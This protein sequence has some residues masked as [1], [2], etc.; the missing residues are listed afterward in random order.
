MG[1]N[2]IMII[3]YLTT[4]EKNT[5]IFKSK[6]MVGVSTKDIKE[7]EK[8]IGWE[9]PIAYKE[10]LHLAGE[11]CYGLD[12]FPGRFS[13]FDL[14]N[15]DSIDELNNKLKKYGVLQERPIW[16]FTE[17]DG[18]EQFYFFYLD[19]NVEDPR[20]WRAELTD[21]TEIGDGEKSLSAFYN[22]LIDYSLDYRKRWGPAL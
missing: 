11:S 20:V 12:L 10:F 4:L 21:I 5:S 15:P 2:E 16:V 6:P 22:E 17:M 14:A 18:Y 3:K 7:V 9:F 8:Q 1:F 19:E 13:L